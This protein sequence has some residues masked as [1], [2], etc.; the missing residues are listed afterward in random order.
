MSGI[1]SSV[2]VISGINSGQLIE[3]LLAVEARPKQL[4]QA[5][6][7]TLQNQRAAFLDINSSLLALK[8]S[9]GAFRLNKVFDSAKAASSDSTILNATAASGAQPGTYTLLASRLVSTQQQISR[10]VADRNVTGLG[11]TGVSLSVGGGRLDSETALASL[12]GGAG[13]ARGKIRVTDAAGGSS[14]VDLSTAVTVK[15]VLD[16]IN[17][18]GSANVVASVSGDRLV[19]TDNSGGSGQFRVDNTP[20]SSTATSLGI[21]AVGSS[22]VILGQ[23]I[24]TLSAQTTLASLNDGAGVSLRSNTAVGQPDFVI[25]ARDGTA[26]KIELGRREESTTPSGGGSPTITVRQ[27]A[28][29]TLQDVVTRINNAAGNNGKVVASIDTTNNRLV[30]T[31]TTGGSG[32]LTVAEADPA[33][34]TRT[35][36]RD[37]GLL[38]QSGGVASSTVSGRRLIAGLNSTLLSSLNGGAGVGAGTFQITGSLLTGAG[39]VTLAPISV[40][41]DDSVS[42]IVARINDAAKTSGAA[43]VASLNS[44][45][46]GINLTDTRGG[47]LVIADQGGGTVAQQLKIATAGAGAVNSGNLRTRTL[48]GAT[49]LSTLNARAGVGLGTFTTFDSTGAQSTVS[50]D[51]NDRTID[52][53]IRKINSGS[54]GVRARVND[55]GDGLLLYDNSNAGALAIRVQDTTGSVAAKLN[56]AGVS[57]STAAADNKIDG[58]FTESIALSA[59]DTL[60]QVVTKI[61]GAGFGVTAAVVGDGSASSPFRLTL[62]AKSSGSA[63]RTVVDFSGADLGLSTLSEGRDAVAFYGSGDP[64]NAVLLTSASNTFDS[65]IQGVS[66]TLAK[67]STTPVTI[68]VSRDVDGIE[69]AVKTLVDT[70]NTALDKFKKYD[71]YDDDTKKKGVLLGDSTVAQL[72]DGIYRAVQGSPLNVPGQLRS[73]LDIGVSVGSGGKITFDTQKFRAAYAS[74]PQGVQDLLSAFDQAPTN[75]AILDPNGNPFP[76]V[77]V[78]STGS[79]PVYNKLGVAEIIRNLADNLTDSVNGVLTRRDQ[80]L[81]AQISQQNDRIAGFDQK[82]EEKRTRLQAQFTAM[83]QAIAQLRTQQ[84]ALGQIQSIAG[85]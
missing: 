15:D 35:T 9:A 18:N 63:G 53:V 10:G 41:A 19:I 29:S 32:N 6:V 12:N 40:T 43:V 20:G 37:L 85:R 82:I 48:S 50:I 13:V 55:T 23:R 51:A 62:T 49:A 75:N 56:I 3:Q 34:P 22:G 17:T 25:T 52:D 47:A 54:N 72:R 68:T 11:L 69:G 31:D 30:L 27:T 24:N 4:A 28:A 61:N 67:A 78:N 74:N 36:A 39:Q 81:N 42:D 65:A 21:A 66:V 76:G 64:A 26:L 38:T 14:I 5:R 44:A 33:D 8:T 80:D 73:L 2:G 7:A 59:T 1:S 83:E 84:N 70:L 16:A 71:S 79:A 77:T 46:N 57:A 45:G 60:D 58:T